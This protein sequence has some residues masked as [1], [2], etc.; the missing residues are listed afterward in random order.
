MLQEQF[1][2]SRWWSQMVAVGYE[3]ERGMRPDGRG[4][5]AGRRYE[6]TLSK[7][8]AAPR[9]T[10]WA[11][12]QDPGTLAQWLPDASFEVSKSAPPKLLELDWADQTH[13]AVKFYERSGRT[14]VVVSHGG[15]A[16]DQ[17]EGRQRYW[18]DALDRLRVLMA[19]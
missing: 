18:S 16:E 2:V 3:N 11:A 19:G 12:W 9:V 8:V 10:A 7:V 13:V 1:G 5:A 15:F 14:R 4:F 17:T 6:I